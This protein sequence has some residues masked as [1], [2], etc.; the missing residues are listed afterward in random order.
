MLFS[1]T[2]IGWMY[3][4]PNH[5]KVCKVPE[6]RT[7]RMLQRPR[8]RTSWRRKEWERSRTFREGKQ[9]ELLEQTWLVAA[10]MVGHKV[11]EEGHRWGL[12]VKLVPVDEDSKVL[13]E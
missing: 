11:V 5:C 13:E 7:V 4:L 12:V 2:S 10:K 6:R 8:K 3:T 9:E 1:K